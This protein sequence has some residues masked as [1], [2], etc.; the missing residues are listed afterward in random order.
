VSTCDRFRPLFSALIDG[1]L[2]SAEAHEV[3]G[4]LESCEACRYEL[5]SLQELDVH[6]SRHLVIPDIASR[7]TA[8]SRAAEAQSLHNSVHRLPTYGLSFAIAIAI[9]AVIL[10]AMLPDKWGKK[11]DRS[12]SNPDT[13]I[14]ARLVRSTGPVQV[15]PP[16]TVDW[17]DI[18]ADSKHA[19][20]SGSRLR[21]SERIVCELETTKNATIRMNEAAE[22]II[23]D[24]KQVELVAGQLWC[25]ASNDSDIDISVAV[26]NV[27]S[28]RIA[29]FTCPSGSE[30]QCDAKN[31]RDSY[32]SVSS[33][34]AQANVTIGEFSC[35]VSP[36]ETVLID[37]DNKIDR[38]SNVG[39]ASKVWQLPL[40]AL[41]GNADRELD[42]LLK[43]VLAPIG[44]TKAMHLNEQQ[45]RRLGP[46]GSIPLLVYA[47][48]E[49]SPEH[50]SLRQ[51]AVRMASDLADQRAISLLT[52]LQD[53]PD[54]YIA[55][56]AKST[57]TRILNSRQ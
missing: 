15:L 14:V 23:R 25:H 11:D 49:K 39:L 30:M 41:H 32:V 27:D 36:G 3:E 29:S 38:T 48:H 9:A 44:M 17:L 31:D 56:V 34:N 6:L 50:A 24:P 55:G 20:L 54:T 7:V 45:I 47:I 4:H 1:E 26:K 52:T 16:D 13:L 53:D 18:A 51:T 8:I 33:A 28:P 22:L 40:L 10:F 42:S 2:E 35:A 43:S 46:P 19:L 5:Q 57:L 12:S 37:S 21:T